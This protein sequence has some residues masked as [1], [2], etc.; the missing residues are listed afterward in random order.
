MRN[1]RQQRFDCY[2][3]NQA[4][5][6]TLLQI[7]WQ[8]RFPTEKYY[9]KDTNA[10]RFPTINHVESTSAFEIVQEPFEDA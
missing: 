7:G 5:K 8:V 6:P 9:D 2:L 3:E 4:S 1:K 10:R